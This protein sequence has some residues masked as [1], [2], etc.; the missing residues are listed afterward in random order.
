[1]G[2]IADFEQRR[3]L[4]CLVLE[5]M[6]GFPSGEQTYIVRSVSGEEAA[7]VLP[8]REAVLWV[9]GHNLDG[10]E[11]GEAGFPAYFQSRAQRIAHDS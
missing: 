5:M 1:M 3:D 8:T 2:A 7:N 11:G 10:N 4:I 6:T 9:P